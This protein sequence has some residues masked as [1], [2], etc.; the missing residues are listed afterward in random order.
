MLPDA[1]VR[2]RH[3]SALSLRPVSFCRRAVSSTTR[4]TPTGSCTSPSLTSAPAWCGEAGVARRGGRGAPRA[5]V[6]GGAPRG[7]PTFL[8][9]AH[10]AYSTRLCPPLPGCRRRRPH[11]CWQ[12]FPA[13]RHPGPDEQG[14]RQHGRGRP[15]LIRAAGRM[16]AEPEPQGECHVWRGGRQGKRKRRRLL[17]HSCHSSLPTHGSHAAHAVPLHAHRPPTRTSTTPSSTPARSRWTFRSCPRATAPEPASAA[18]TSRAVS[19]SAATSHAAHTSTLSWSSSTTPCRPST[20][21]PRTTSLTTA[22]RACLP[23]R[24]SCW[25]R[26]RSSSCQ[27]GCCVARCGGRAPEGGGRRRRAARLAIGCTPCN[28]MHRPVCS[29][30]ALDPCHLAAAGATASPSWTRAS[31]STTAPG[32]PRRRRCWAACCL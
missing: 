8:C 31:A 27:S 21:T 23:T 28:W 11:W 1:R 18:S 7:A 16:A 2:P 26:T 5:V 19:G 6:Q 3:S 25:S 10:F 4:P 32:P 14:P 17:G 13:Q 12:V 9:S 22:S 15:H 29:R 20:T 30:S 24:P